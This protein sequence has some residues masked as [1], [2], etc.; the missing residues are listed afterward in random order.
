MT[1]YEFIS[2]LQ[3]AL[4]RAN[5]MSLPN[6]EVA[7][8]FVAPNSGFCGPTIRPKFVGYPEGAAAARPHEARYGLTRMQIERI[9]TS[10]DVT[11]P[12]ESGIV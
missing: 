5:T 9:L 12:P 11:L 4:D 1:V 6:R 2:R 7:I 3:A 10:F 8:T